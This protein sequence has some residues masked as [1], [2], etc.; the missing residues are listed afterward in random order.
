MKRNELLISRVNCISSQ[1][2]LTS[3]NDF[4]RLHPQTI[5]YSMSFIRHRKILAK[6][7]SWK[8]RPQVECDPFISQNYNQTIY[9]KTTDRNF[10]TGVF[11][12]FMNIIWKTL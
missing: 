4:S 2:L 3:V 7:A 8:S 6:K 9:Q 12:G 1:L 11:Y 5:T 10:K